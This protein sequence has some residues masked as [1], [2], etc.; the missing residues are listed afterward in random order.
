MAHLLGVENLRLTVGSRLLLDE[1]TLGLEDGTRVGVLGPNGAGKS[2]FLAAL[3]G[4]RE[5]DGGRV[6]RTGGVSV[7]VLS[8]ADDLPPGATVRTAIHGQAPEHEWASDPAVRDIHAGLIADLD[9][10]ADVATLSGGQRRRVALAAVLTRRADVVILD[11]PTNH[12]DVEG[13][14]WLARH[15]R[16]RFNGPGG[17]ASGALVTVTHDRWFLDA[18]C[19]D[20]WEVVPGIDPG[21]RRPQVAGRIETYDGGYAAYVLARAERARQAAVA[22]VKRENLLRKELAWLRRGAPARTSKPRFRIEA[23]EALIAQVSQ[24]VEA[25]GAS[26]LESQVTASH[27]RIFTIVELDSDDVTGLTEAVRSAAADAEVTGPDEVRLVGAELE[28]VRALARKADY[29]VEWDIPEEISMDTYL[30]RKKANS[31]KYAQVPEVSFLRTYVREDTVKC[32]CFYD[33]PDEEAVVRA[34]EAV[35]TPIDRLHALEG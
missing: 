8:Q 11:E 14:D 9:L 1:V 6:T 29:L 3:A 24:A 18:I 16:A 31:P 19:T 4:R 5:P 30:A 22:A 27:E 12:L 17:R 13:V 20:V 33:A 23:A 15:L 35:S 34:R 21:G 32:L 26:V 7:A 10:S 25:A 2:T 28:D